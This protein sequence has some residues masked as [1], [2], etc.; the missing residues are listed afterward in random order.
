MKL[1]FS[2]SVALPQPI[3]VRLTLVTCFYAWV[4]VSFPWFV[5]C[6]FAFSFFLCVLVLLC[7]EACYGFLPAA[8]ACAYK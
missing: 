3:N 5:F 6:L 7:L 1:V 8:K 4:H 2:S